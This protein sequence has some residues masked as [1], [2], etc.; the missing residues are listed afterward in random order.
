VTR[1]RCGFRRRRTS[2]DTPLSFI[3]KGGVLDSSGEF[4]E[5]VSQRAE[6]QCSYLREWV[7][8]SREGFGV[9]KL[10]CYG[11][12]SRGFL[13][14]AVVDTRH[15]TN[16]RSRSEVLETTRREADRNTRADACV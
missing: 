3:P 11:L 15:K 12:K 10:S 1:N 5:V 2:N 8:E 7:A 4:R 9:F 6:H 13:L 14:A 16:A